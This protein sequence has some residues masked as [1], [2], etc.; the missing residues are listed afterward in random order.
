MVEWLLAL[1]ITTVV[2]ESTGIYC[3]PFYEIL[4]ALGIEFFL[5][6][7]DTPKMCL[8]ERLIS[9]MFNGS[10]SSTVMALF[11]HVFSLTL[12]LLSLGTNF[13][14]EMSWCAIARRTSNTF[15]KC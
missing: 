15:K 8:A 2:M 10:N 12:L 11:E 14:S 7:L 5:S 6:I 3:V 4:V 13:G 9:K 1:H